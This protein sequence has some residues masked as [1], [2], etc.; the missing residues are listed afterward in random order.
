VNFM[1]VISSNG[2]S[3]FGGLFGAVVQ[4]IGAFGSLWFE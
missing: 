3:F 1:G 2:R 4:K